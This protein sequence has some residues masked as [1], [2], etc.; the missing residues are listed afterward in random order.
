MSGVL[1]VGGKCPNYE[2]IKESIDN[3]E[4]IVAAD[5]GYDYAKMHNISPDYVIGD[6]DSVQNRTD[7]QELPEEKRKIVS[8]EKDAT[9]TELGLD[10][11]WEKGI[12]KVMI[13]GGGGGRFDHLIGILTLFERNPHPYQWINHNARVVAVDTTLTINTEIGDVLSFFPI[14]SSPCTMES[15]G[16]KW[17]LNGL[18]WIRGDMGISNEAL[19]NTIEIQV[20]EG[21][22]IMVKTLRKERIVE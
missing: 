10:Y 22:L 3:A 16:L 5:S 4:M 1:I 13:I 8:R 9:D 12:K 17:P 18:K 21:R 2:L 11:L 7:I 15:K 19:E 6:M 14:G 20:K